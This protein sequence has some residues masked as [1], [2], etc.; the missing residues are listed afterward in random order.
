MQALSDGGKQL[1]TLEKSVLTT[2]LKA[3]R[4][5]KHDCARQSIVVESIAQA[6]SASTTMRSSL[7]VIVPAVSL[8]SAIPAALAWK[9][10]SSESGSTTNPDFYQV[11][12]G[13]IMQLLGLLTFIWPTLSHPRLSQLAWFWIWI[14]AAFSALCAMLSIP[15]FLAVS[16]TWSFV[17]AFAGVLGQAIVQLQVIT[18]I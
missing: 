11:V 3:Q 6:Y 9:H 2:G 15:L 7:I 18:S 10:G 5:K 12:A 13:S 16:S 4:T 14:L 8:L 17:I 1:Y